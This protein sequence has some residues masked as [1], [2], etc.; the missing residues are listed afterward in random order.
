M[1][2]FLLRAPAWRLVSPAFLEPW[3]GAAA[4][5]KQLGLLRFRVLGLL[6]YAQTVS[7]N[8]FHYKSEKK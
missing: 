8:T 6:S 1:F 5:A 3:M 4:G 2:Q 7:G